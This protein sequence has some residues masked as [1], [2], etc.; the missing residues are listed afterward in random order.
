V[1]IGGAEIR[2]EAG[3]SIWTES[4]HKYDRAQFVQLA[5]EAQLEVIDVWTDREERFSVQLL[6]PV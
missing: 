6:Q 3:E 2:F 5:R 1:H 4:C